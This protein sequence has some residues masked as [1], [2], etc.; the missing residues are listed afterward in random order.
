MPPKPILAELA[1]GVEAFESRN[2]D[3]AV[4][5]ANNILRRNPFETFA[6]RLLEKTYFVSQNH[7]ELAKL[8]RRIARFLPGYSDIEMRIASSK[9]GEGKIKQ[10]RA[11]FDRA[12]ASRRSMNPNRMLPYG[13]LILA[14]VKHDRQY[15][16]YMIDRNKLSPSRF[17][18]AL[19]ILRQLEERFSPQQD[20][21]T[22]NAQ[23]LVSLGEI[24]RRCLHLSPCTFDGPM[25]NKAA[26][27]AVIGEFV[28]SPQDQKFAWGDNLFTADGLHAIRTFLLESTIWHNDAQKGGGYLGAYEANG[29]M[30]PMLLRAKGEIISVL[31]EFGLHDPLEQVW[32]YKNIVGTKGV[33]VHA[34]FSQININVWLTP[35]HFNID[36][37]EGSGGL[38][39]YSARAD[40]QMSFPEYN[41]NDDTIDAKVRESER[42]LVP[43][44]YNRF[45]IFDSAHFHGSNGARFVD[46]HDGHRI[47]MTFLFGVR[48]VSSDT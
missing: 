44:G 35:N 33:G 5:I 24:Y 40:S 9:L 39:I 14:R 25:I 21:L 41:D 12:L 26:L 34:D 29:L 19:G 23:D 13:Q 10:A 38:V 32:C 22:L 48:R 36:T 43:Y 11:L 42:H 31:A 37:G 8:D 1:R 15:L 30:H 28:A 45:M 4:K 47:N 16:Q 7:N 2:F 20:V 17:Q 18:A 3:L 46:S 6:Y 27:R